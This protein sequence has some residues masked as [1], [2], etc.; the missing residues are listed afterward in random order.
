MDAADTCDSKPRHNK[1]RGNKSPVSRHVHEQ[2][3]GKALLHLLGERLHLI[4]RHV[5]VR[6]VDRDEIDA[7]D[8]L[9]GMHWSLQGAEALLPIR[10]LYKSGR[11][12]ELHN[13]R[14]RNLK[15]VAFR[16]A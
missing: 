16:A 8:D 13:W 6:I 10:A 14:V 7:V 11:L 9:S 2:D 3:D 12:D 5:V 15:Q 4:L 1:R